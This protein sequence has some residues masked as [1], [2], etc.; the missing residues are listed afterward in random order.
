MLVQDPETAEISDMPVAAIRT[1]AVHFEFSPEMIGGALITL[2]MALGRRHGFRYGQGIS[3]V[4]C[5]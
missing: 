2:A 3:I 5:G 4:E 1:S